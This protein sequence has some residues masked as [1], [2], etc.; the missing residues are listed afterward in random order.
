ME[1][2]FK[3]QVKIQKPVAEVFDGVYNPKKLTGYFTSEAS[4]PLVEGTTV[5]WAFSEPAV[6]PF[7]VQVRQVVTNELIVLTW[8]GGEDEADTRVEMRFTPVDAHSTLVSISE[9]GWKE[10]PKGLELSY[11]NCG[12]WMHMVCCLKAYL[13]YGINLRKGCF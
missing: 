10:T 5:Q 4:G 13:E 9:S 2:K 12:G 3:V 11:G 6:P 8:G 1:L 7:P